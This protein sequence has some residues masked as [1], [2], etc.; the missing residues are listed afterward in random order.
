MSEQVPDSKPRE[1]PEPVRKRE[2][3]WLEKLR[4]KLETKPQRVKRE[5]PS[6][7]PLH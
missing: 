3:S 1:R 7:Y 2:P 4:R 6:V 5:D